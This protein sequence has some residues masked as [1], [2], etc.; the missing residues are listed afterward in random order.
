L[1]AAAPTSALVTFD[2][3]PVRVVF[4]AATSARR[5][6]S[7][8]AIQTAQEAHRARSRETCAALSGSRDPLLAKTRRSS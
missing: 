2:G 3:I 5:R 6:T 4:S 1:T 8:L 7:L